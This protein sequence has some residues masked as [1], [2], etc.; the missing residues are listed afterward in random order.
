MPWWVAVQAV[1]PVSTSSPTSG[2]VAG[3]PRIPI[4][5]PIV[6]SWIVFS[7]TITGSTDEPRT[8]RAEVTLMTGLRT[9]CLLSRMMT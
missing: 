9:G 2:T 5:G 6:C 3:A 7:G 1:Q 4:S 8:S